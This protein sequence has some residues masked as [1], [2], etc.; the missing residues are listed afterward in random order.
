MLHLSLAQVNDAQMSGVINK[1]WPVPCTN[2]YAHMRAAKIKTQIQKCAK[3]TAFF[4]IRYDEINSL[5]E[6]CGVDFN[7]KRPRQGL[8]LCH[9]LNVEVA[10]RIVHTM[11]FRVLGNFSFIPATL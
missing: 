4:D 2:K 7:I 10:M 8:L 6:I 3:D 5:S 9:L 11:A 1:K